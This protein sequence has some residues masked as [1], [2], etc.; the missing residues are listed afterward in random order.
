VNV[1]V[2]D[3]EQAGVTSYLDAAE[4]HKRYEILRDEVAYMRAAIEA[5]TTITTAAP[6]DSNSAATVAMMK[7][8]HTVPDEH[9]PLRLLFSCT[10]HLGTCTLFTEPL[11]YFMPTEDEERYY[12]IL[13]I[14]VIL[15]N[16]VIAICS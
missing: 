13:Y 14:Y 15:L 4:F 16:T 2:R 12:L 1:E 11:L 3:T 9:D 6:T 10:Y 8:V 5:T 7:R